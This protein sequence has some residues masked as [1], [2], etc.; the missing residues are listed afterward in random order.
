[1]KRAVLVLAFGLLA[2]ATLAAQSAGV[3]LVLKN[4]NIYTVDPRL[5]R[6]ELPP[7]PGPRARSRRGP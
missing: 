1:M 5:G 3:D 2:A 6:V 7:R 4:G